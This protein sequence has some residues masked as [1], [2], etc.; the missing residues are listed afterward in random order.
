MA[1]AGLFS[2]IEDM[3]IPIKQLNG[4]ETATVRTWGFNCIIGELLRAVKY[5]PWYSSGNVK[6]LSL[7]DRDY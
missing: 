6:I 3:E 1:V 5:N 2:L 4:E 7:Y